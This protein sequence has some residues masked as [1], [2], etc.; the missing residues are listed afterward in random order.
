[1][2]VETATDDIVEDEPFAP[3]ARWFALAM[4][5]E[6]LGGDDELATA[7]PDGRPSLRAVLLKGADAARLCLLHQYRQPQGRGT[8]G[9]PAGGAVL[10][11]EVARP[12][13]PHRGRRS[14]PVAPAE[15]DAYFAGRA[16]DSQIG[17]W[18]SDQS[19]LLPN[20]AELE[21]P[22]L[23]RSP[24]RYAEQPGVPRP[25]QLVGLSRRARLHRV[26]AGPA[27]SAARP[28]SLFT[29][30]GERWCKARLYP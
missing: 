21:K 23:P 22:R 29:R 19:R 12:T 10:S 1:M 6:P 13:G 7:R 26:L 11:L 27:V 18:A 16:R 8:G 28:A 25:P 20:R 5:S 2:S 3:F 15:A 24:A 9:E 14:E 4:Q 17:A 30:D